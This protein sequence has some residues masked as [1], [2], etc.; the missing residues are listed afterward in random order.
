[1]V[2]SLREL[3][4]VVGAYE[5]RKNGVFVPQLNVAKTSQ[6]MAHHTPAEAKI[7]PH[8]GVFAP[9]RHEYLSLIQ[10]APLPTML[11]KTALAF[12]IGTGTGVI[13]ALL[14][15][16]GVSRVIAT[17]T[18]VSAIACATENIARLGL[19]SN[20]DVLCA[21][22]FPPLDKY[23]KAD[24]IVCNPPWLPAR[25]NSV[26]EAAV[27]DEGSQ[28][29]RAFL[30]GLAQHLQPRGEGWLIMS[31]LAE[32]LGLR[33][34]D[35][36]LTWIAA[37]GLTVLAQRSIAAMHPKTFDENDALFFARSQEMTSLW[38]LGVATV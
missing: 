7:Y 3:L 36:L 27:Y 16:R 11:Q 35:E 32:H 33:S 9:I 20:I 13:A 28:M 25:P 17:D 37:A 5:W 12:D 1:M 30:S 19:A 34:R 15:Q 23:G 31:D 26:L 21:D 18:N 38:R 6:A 14:A 8:Y 24:L 4:G 2:V 29:L 10:Q 22:M